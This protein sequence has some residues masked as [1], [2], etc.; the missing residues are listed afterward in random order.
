MSLPKAGTF[1]TDAAAI[2]RHVYGHGATKK[3]ARRFGVSVD[4]A[5]IWLAGRFPQNRTQELAAVVSEELDRIDARNQEIRRQLG[6]AG[7]FE[8]RHEARG[9]TAR[10]TAVAMDTPAE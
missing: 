4:A 10:R 8:P 5:K 2:L 7:D 1:M 6:I 9:R 3:I